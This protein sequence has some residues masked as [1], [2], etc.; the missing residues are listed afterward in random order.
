MM[1]AFFAGLFGAIAINIVA[2]VIVR[3]ITLLTVKESK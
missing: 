1:E 3:G 2:F